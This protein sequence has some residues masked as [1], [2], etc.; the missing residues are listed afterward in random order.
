MCTVD[1]LPAVRSRAG[2]LTIAPCGPVATHWYVPS[3]LAA[4]SAS[5]RWC[6]NA[7]IVSSPPVTTRWP[8]RRGS[9]GWPS[10]SHPVTVKPEPGVHRRMAVSP[11]R[12]NAER[13][14]TTKSGSSVV[15][16]LAP[17]TTRQLSES[18]GRSRNIYRRGVITR[19]SELKAITWNV[20]IRGRI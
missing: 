5:E 20:W 11:R 3:S 7:L 13:G 4:V 10:C 18:T 17:D 16:V 15:D 12:M 6:A 2:R 14:W 1:G 8:V 9:T 19:S